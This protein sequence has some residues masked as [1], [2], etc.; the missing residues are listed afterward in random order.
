MPEGVRNS[1]KKK[2]KEEGMEDG[3]IWCVVGGHSVSS[4][5]GLAASGLLIPVIVSS[6]LNQ[7]HGCTLGLLINPLLPGNIYYFTRLFISTLMKAI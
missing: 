2:E 3:G 7:V 5:I 1:G 4:A 6:S